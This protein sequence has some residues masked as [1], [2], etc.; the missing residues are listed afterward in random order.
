MEVVV[1][2]SFL[3]FSGERDKTNISLDLFLIK[4]VRPLLW[5]KLLHETLQNSLA[6]MGSFSKCSDIRLTLRKGTRSPK[7]LPETGVHPS[8][9]C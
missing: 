9:Q 2:V 5:A 3:S 6:R 4:I 8:R 1:V 7:L